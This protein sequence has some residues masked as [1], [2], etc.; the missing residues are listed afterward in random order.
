MKALIYAAKSIAN[1][2]ISLVI[3]LVL[4]KSIELAIALIIA[5]VNFAI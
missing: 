3:L 2:T 4:N 5:V 1:T